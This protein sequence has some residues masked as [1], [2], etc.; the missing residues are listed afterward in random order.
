MSYHSGLSR[1][2]PSIQQPWFVIQSPTQRAFVSVFMGVVVFLG[3]GLLDWFVTRQ[4]LPP[5][6]LMLGGLGVALFVSV[7][8]FQILS[9]LRKRYQ[10]ISAQLRR[11]LDLNHH[12]RNALQ[13]IVYHNGPDRSEQAI[14]QVKDEVTR[15]ESALREASLSLS[16]GV[17]SRGPQSQGD[18]P[19]SQRRT[20]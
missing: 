12:I 1:L 3:G 17:E 8:V 2:H 18:P 7:L 5:R 4:Y 11:M 20:A 9:D 16:G 19:R 10:A 15:I 13:V 14:Q 6:S